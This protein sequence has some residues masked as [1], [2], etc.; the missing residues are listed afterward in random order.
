MR[1][2]FLNLYVLRNMNQ[3]LHEETSNLE[4]T[5]DLPK[6]WRGALDF[7]NLGEGFPSQNLGEN[8]PTPWRKNELEKT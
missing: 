6:P 3:I 7:L 1:K 4:K 2:Y 8:I 5:L